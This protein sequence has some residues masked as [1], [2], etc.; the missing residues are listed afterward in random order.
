MVAKSSSK[1]L[2]SS[3]DQDDNFS[4]KVNFHYFGSGSESSND[5]HFQEKEYFKS[6]FHSRIS[7]IDSPTAIQIERRN[8]AYLE[9]L[10][11]IYVENFSNDYWVQSVLRN[12]EATNNRDPDLLKSCN[13]LN[14]KV[15]ILY[16]CIIYV[17]KALRRVFRLFKKWFERNIL[18]KLPENC[19]SIKF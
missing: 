2:D 8:K 14:E 4:T 17:Y 13:S 10:R 9:A 6:S 16:N 15:Q 18:E 7:S 5:E 11:S 1:S 12:L 3:T 19:L